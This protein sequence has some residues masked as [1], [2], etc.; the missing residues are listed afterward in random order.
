ML[1]SKEFYDARDVGLGVYVALPIL[2]F[3][4]VSQ[5]VYAVDF[6]SQNP[7]LNKLEIPKNNQQISTHKDQETNKFIFVHEI[8]RIFSAKTIVSSDD[9]GVEKITNFIWASH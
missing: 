4:D 1:L 8:C 3:Q 6:E 2:F 9:C 7:Y 5:Y